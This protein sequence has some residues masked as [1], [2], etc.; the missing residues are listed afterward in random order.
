MLKGVLPR[1][2]VLSLCFP[3][4]A[5]DRILRRMLGPSWRGRARSSSKS[6]LAAEVAPP[7]LAVV[8]KARNVQ[9]ITCLTASA[10]AL[11]LRCG[12]A[13]ADA[14]ARVPTLLVEEA[15]PERDAALL[16]LLADWCDRYTPLVALDGAD[17]LF[18]DITGCAHLFGGEE[19]LLA[20]ALA[21]LADQGFAVCGAIAD[22]P[23]S[24]WAEARYGDGG[25]IA[26]GQ[27]PRL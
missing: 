24:A 25:C 22:T 18:L 8:A 23:G 2:R 17:G 15:E 26:P 16:N 6:A 13:L 12:E 3:E 11:G 10:R 4:L 1:Q 19:A 7:T 14:R 9:R 20:D 27:Q 21:R 5:C